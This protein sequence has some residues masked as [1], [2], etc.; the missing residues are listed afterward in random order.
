MTALLTLGTSYVV[1]G[2]GCVW[3][4]VIHGKGGV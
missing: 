1:L 4:W 2:A 3:W